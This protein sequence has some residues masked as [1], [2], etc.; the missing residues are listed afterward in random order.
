MKTFPNCRNPRPLAGP[1]CQHRLIDEARL[2]PKPG[3][4]DSRGNGAHQDPNLALMERSARSLQPTFHALAQQSWRRPADIAL[5]ETVGRLGTR[6]RSADDAGDLG[7]QYPPRRYLGAGPGGRDGDA[8]GEGHAQRITETA[9][10]LARLP[11]AGAPKTFSKGLR[12]LPLAGSGARKKR[13]ALSRISPPWR[14]RSYCAA[15]RRGQRGAGPF[16]DALMAI[17]T[18]LAIPAYLPRGWRS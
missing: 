5:R 16:L 11:D 17:M 1:N 14:C 3:L 8:R 10:A 13:S 9:A 15:D 18:R 4:V 2:S 6:R 12:Q 7:S